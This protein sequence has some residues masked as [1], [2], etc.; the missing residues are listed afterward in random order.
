MKRYLLP[1]LPCL[2]LASP[3]LALDPH[4]AQVSTVTAQNYNS[5]TGTLTFTIT[6][7]TSHAVN[8]GT[9]SYFYRAFVKYDVPLGGECS[10]QLAQG[11][12]AIAA[13]VTPISGEG[14]VALETEVESVA[15]STVINLQIVAKHAGDPMKIPRATLVIEGLA[16]A[17]Q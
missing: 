11:S 9:N 14:F 6:S 2:A 17:T 16:G 4:D 12:T 3:L 15:A 1:L 8:S 7:L 5:I 13:T 10:L